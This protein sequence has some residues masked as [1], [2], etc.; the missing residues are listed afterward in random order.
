MNS[1]R[2]C[3]GTGQSASGL[4]MLKA[5]MLGR[6]RIQLVLGTWCA[7]R[8]QPLNMDKFW[9]IRIDQIGRKQVGLGAGDVAAMGGREGAGGWS[10][11]QRTRH[12]PPAECGSTMWK[13]GG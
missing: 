6:E 10:I 9:P 2:P 1:G 7:P 13:T 4:M 8:L 12:Y 11:T 5:H 3:G